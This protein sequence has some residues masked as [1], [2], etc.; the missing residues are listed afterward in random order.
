MLPSWAEGVRQNDSSVIESIDLK[1][2][3]AQYRVLI[4]S[5][6]NEG[7]KKGVFRKMDVNLISSA[8]LGVLDGLALQWIMDPN[9]LE[10]KN[11]TSVILDVFLNG[12]KK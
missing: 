5:I 1:G 11:A 8:F 10:I 6:L 2:V 9:A 7:I 12:I 4:S 3:Y